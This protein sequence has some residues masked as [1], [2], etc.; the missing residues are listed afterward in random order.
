MQANNIE[1]DFLA[2]RQPYLPQLAQWYFDEW[3]VLTKAQSIQVVEARLQEYL[4]A[5]RI[6]LVITASI[7]GELAGAVQLK[8]REM[9]IYPDKEHWLGGVY[10]GE[11]FRGNKVAST[12]V[13]RA[14]GVARDMGVSAL[15][16]QTIRLDGGLYRKLGWKPVEKVMYRG[17]EVQVMVNRLDK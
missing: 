6:P 8:F 2:N 11:K 14:I 16:L 3:G 17:L 9:T 15:Y 5:D 10:V 12:I 7:A 4:N 13:R 1:L